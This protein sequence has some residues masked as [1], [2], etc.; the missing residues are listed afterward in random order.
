MND[1]FIKDLG[2]YTVLYQIHD[3]Y[4]ITCDVSRSRIHGD[5]TIFTVCYFLRFVCLYIGLQFITIYDTSFSVYSPIFHYL[6]SPIK[7]IPST[8]STKNFSHLCFILDR[9][10][11]RSLTLSQPIPSVPSYLPWLSYFSIPRLDIP[12]H[13]SLFSLTASLLWPL[14][15]PFLLLFS[16]SIRFARP[17]K[18]PIFYL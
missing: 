16:I 12:T 6:T 14:H 18:F 15:P 4:C 8:S 3:P 1:R 17:R 9:C 7:F 5:K 11:Y 10:I 13:P 2:W